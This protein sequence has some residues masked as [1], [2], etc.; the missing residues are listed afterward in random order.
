[1]PLSY[2]LQSIANK[3]KNPYHHIWD[4]CCDHGYLGMAL[5]S[6]NPSSTI[7]FVDISAHIM[8][9]VK[10]GLSTQA[11]SQQLPYKNWHCHTMSVNDLPLDQYPGRHLIIIAGV[12]GDLAAEFIQQLTAR[13]SNVA[14]EFII[15][16]VHHTFTLRQQLIAL[17]YTLIDESLISENKRFYE[18]LHVTRNKNQGIAISPIGDKLWHSTKQCEKSQYLNRLITHYQKVSRNS[19]DA[20]RALYAYQAL[21]NKLKCN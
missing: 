19:S 14:L 9:G 11:D 5:L 2:R 6:S 15:C 10:N 1:M 13:F 21:A 12:G 8:K 16:P 18:I 3:I 7:H 17:N 4:T 20:L